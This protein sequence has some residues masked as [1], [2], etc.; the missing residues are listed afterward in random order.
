MLAT[1]S[2]GAAS[3][4]EVEPYVTDDQDALAAA[5]FEPAAFV[6]PNLI[7]PWGVSF[8]PTSPFWVSNQGSGTSTLYDSEGMP[9]SLIVGIPQFGSVAGPTGQVFNPTTSFQLS[10]GGTGVFFFA[11]L[12]GSISGWNSALTTAEFVVPSATPLRPAVYT[13][14]ALASHG[15]ADFLYAANNETG[16]IDVFDSSYASVALPNGFVDPGPNPDGLVPFNVQNLN[17]LLYVT[18]AMGGPDADEADLGQ[19]F[20]SVF[21]PDGSF[22]GRIA[23]GGQLSSPW[24]VAI[25]PD[26]FGKFGGALLIGNFSEEFGYINA[27]DPDSGEFLGSL[28]D[29]DGDTLIIP[30]MWSILFGN[31]GSGG[32]PEDLYF[33]AGIGDELHGVF[34]EISFSPVPLPA[35]LPLLGGAL[36]GLMGFGRRRET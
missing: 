36:L 15:G 34:G 7:N 23:D 32:D 10:T 27:F 19:G 25:A 31:G 11:N 30:Y 4:F 1:T 24:G 12:D 2:A 26:G 8:S 21:N 22:V 14:L 17:G 35:G 6:D 9:Q 3:L 20:V 13:G 18:Y 33:T 5:G 28:L 16:R 29:E